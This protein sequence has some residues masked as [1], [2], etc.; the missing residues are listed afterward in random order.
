M[1]Y[2]VSDKPNVKDLYYHEYYVVWK[3][4]KYVIKKYW[5]I[6]DEIEFIPFNLRENYNE[7]MNYEKNT[8]L[9]VSADFSHFLPLS[10]AIESEKLCIKITAF[11]EIL[12]TPA[13]MLWMIKLVLKN[14]ILSF[15]IVLC[16]N[17]LVEQEV[18]ERRVLVIY[19]IY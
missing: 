3:T 12:I 15:L 10:L 19:L 14:F 18:Q 5:M 6:N 1:Y 7:N 11:L 2:P 16:S 8:L 9:V 4:L 17:G 13:L